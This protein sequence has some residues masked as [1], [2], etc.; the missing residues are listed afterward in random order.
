MILRVIH[1]A[2]KDSTAKSK[3]A[4][5]TRF[6]QAAFVTYSGLGKFNLAHEMGHSPS[7]PFLFGFSSNR[8]HSVLQQA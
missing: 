2:A 1:T 5:L 3:I 6:Y 4:S 7:I 8:T